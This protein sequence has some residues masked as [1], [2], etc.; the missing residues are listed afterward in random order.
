[1]RDLNV[2]GA[3]NLSG[4]VTAAQLTVTNL[5][6]S[7]NATLQIPNHLSFTGSSPARTINNGVLGNGGSSSLNGSDTSGTVNVNSGNNPT[8]GCFIS[9]TFQQ[10]FSNQPHV[11]ISPVGEAAGQMQYYV[12]RDNAGFSICSAS[13]PAAN[14]GFAF[15]YFVTN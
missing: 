13:V 3:S 15:D 14:K 4:P 9:I 6:L 5:I 1:M 11:I 8:T 7:G 12:Q 10:R 2:S